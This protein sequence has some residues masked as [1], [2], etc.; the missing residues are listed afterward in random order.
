[1]R[2]RSVLALLALA[3]AF[4]L[5]A[6]GSD[7]N[8]DNASTG[9]ESAAATTTT[10]PAADSKVIQASTENASKPT[11]TIGSKN[12]TEQFILGEIYA[13]ALEAAGYKVK[14]QLN[15]GSEQIALKALK[16]GRVRLKP[17]GSAGGHNGHKSLIGALRSKLG[18][19]SPMLAVMTLGVATKGNPPYELMSATSDRESVA[20]A[21]VWLSANPDFV[22]STYGTVPA[23]AS[24][25]VAAA[26]APARP[27]TSETMLERMAR[28]SQEN[29]LPPR[30]PVDAEQA[31]ATSNGEG[32]IP[33]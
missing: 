31:R 2:S 13:Q 5:A 28:I 33:F 23:P 3:L 30:P 27:A 17:K 10:T 12:F 20:R 18:K 1:M 9:G 21:N 14:K 25:P 26:A 16:A 6:C 7:D 24:R 32:D 22:P 29:K 19:E 15:L 8:N 11:I 4:G